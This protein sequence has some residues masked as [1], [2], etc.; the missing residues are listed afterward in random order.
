VER[1]EFDKDPYTKTNAIQWPRVWVARP[2][3]MSFS[4]LTTTARVHTRVEN[5]V[6]K[7]GRGAYQRSPRQIQASRSTM[8]LQQTYFSPMGID[9]ASTLVL[10]FAP[11]LESKAKP[12]NR[13]LLGFGVE[14]M[15]GVVVG[16]SK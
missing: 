5:A 2:N 7:N 14:S 1:V 15:V 11:H 12:K 16:N 13:H 8:S 4:F 3:P 6:G 10:G 9:I